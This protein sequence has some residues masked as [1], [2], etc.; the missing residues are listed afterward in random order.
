VFDELALLAQPLGLGAVSA[1]MLP[2]HGSLRQVDQTLMRANSASDFRRRLAACG[3]EAETKHPPSRIG[4]SEG[5]FRPL[6]APGAFGG[7]TNLP[8][9]AIDRRNGVHAPFPSVGRSTIPGCGSIGDSSVPNPR[10]DA[11]F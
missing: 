3:A 7:I 6:A 9:R 1:K 2:A 11:R 4:N 5:G 8:V 10:Q